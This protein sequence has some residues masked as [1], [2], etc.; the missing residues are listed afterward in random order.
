MSIIV[1]KF[2]GTSVAN[3][4]R[5]KE[6]I[7]IIK[8]EKQHGNQLVIVVSAMAGVTNQLVT[9]CNEVSSLKTSS[10]LAEY[11]AAL[12]SGEMV[13]ASLLALELQQQG[14]DARSVLAWQLPILTNDNYSKALVEQIS[15]SLLTECIKQDIIPVVAGFQG[16]SNNNRLATLGRG[17][18]DTTASLIAAAMQADRCD[19]YTDV[20]GVFTADPRIVPGAKKLSQI[21]F[22]EMLEFASCGAKVLHPRSLEAAIRYNVPIRVLSSF[23]LPLYHEDSGTLITSREKI[24]ENK[25][26]TGIT[27][28]KNLLKLVVNSTQLNFSKICNLITNHN[29]HLEL[30]ENI[31]E[32]RQ[33]SFI[34]QLSDK[35]K[36]QHLLDDL[37]NANQINN[38]IIDSQISIVSIIGHGIKNDHNFLD[39][40]LTELEKQNISVKMIQISEIKISLLIKDL[41]TE[42]TIRCL[43]QLFELDKLN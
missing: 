29:I 21:S 38:F 36:L 39:M 24:M 9:L 25:K 10:Q 3:I 22:E 23:S 40:V 27:S 30:M 13:T 4:A 16:I 35:N 19:I 32:Y 15:T 31:E 6:I 14:I 34:I 42:K 8:W 26:I 2:G 17:G 18:S 11:D 20:E 28:N 33:Y 1:Q 7:P 12:C 43:H 41:D 5:I 37:K